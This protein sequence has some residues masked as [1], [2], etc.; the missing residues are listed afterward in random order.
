MDAIH[1][2]MEWRKD[3]GERITE[4]PLIRDKFDVFMA[5]SYRFWFCSS[6]F[7]KYYL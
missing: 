6:V 3:H 2:Y 5:R 1:S 7:V 4:S